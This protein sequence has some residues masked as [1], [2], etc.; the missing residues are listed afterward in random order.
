MFYSII[1]IISSS[2]ELYKVRK[3][4]VLVFSISH[5]SSTSARDPAVVNHRSTHSSVEKA[6][7]R[8][9]SHRLTFVHRATS[10]PLCRI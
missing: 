9:R 6:L 7:E 1:I 2:T 5:Q 4:L 8:L 3:G 10:S